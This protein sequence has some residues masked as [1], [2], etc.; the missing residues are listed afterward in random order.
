MKRL[1]IVQTAF[2]GDVV[3]SQPLWAAAAGAWPAAVDLLVQ[4]QWAP[5]LA[6]DPDL[7]QVVVFDKHGRDRGLTGMRRLAGELRRRAYDLALCP[8]PSFRSALLLRLA[9]IPRRVGFAD[10]AGRWLFTDR[11]PRDRAL[12]ETDR[13]LSLLGAVGVRVPD[14][15]RS[16]RLSLGA[17]APRRAVELL[18]RVGLAEGRRF[19]CAHPGSVWAT[20]CWLP[21]RFAAVLSDLADDGLTPVMLGGRD[22]IAL[23]NFVQDRC[24]V[25]PLNLAGR[26]DLPELALLLSRAALLITNDSGPMHVAGAV[27]TPVVA[28]FGGTTTT[29]GYAPVG[30]PRRI[31]EKPVPCRPCGPH[32]RRRCPLDHF[33]CMREIAAA[34]VT[35]AARELLSA[36]I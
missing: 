11:V 20:K 30:S 33:N 31:V 21:E 26:L 24:R 15:R 9:G 13:V 5:L 22:D 34:D 35:T 4:P 29:L 7:D 19:V 25:R 27:G 10:S 17:D 1:L 8:H 12:H 23:A 14:T 18:D 16:P 36:S 28:V 32:G 2:L 3:L 6:A